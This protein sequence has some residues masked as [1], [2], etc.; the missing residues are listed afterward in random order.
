MNPRIKLA[1]LLLA[2]ALAGCVTAVP[3]PV[4]SAR[5][6]QSLGR[7]V[8]QF[9]LVNSSNP[10][11]GPDLAQYGLQAPTDLKTDDSLLNFS[12]RF[13]VLERLDL[14]YETTTTVASGST[15]VYAAKYQWLG[16]SLFKTGKGEWIASL[17]VKYLESDGD[18]D[19]TEGSFDDLLSF[20]EL[21]GHAFGVQQTVG[22][23]FTDWLV[24]SMGANWHRFT[25]RSRFTEGSSGD[26]LHDG[27]HV[28]LLGANASL[29][30]LPRWRKVGMHVCYERG[31]QRMEWTFDSSRERNVPVSAASVGVGFRF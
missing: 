22:Y 10:V 6:P 11:I 13:G 23:Q 25:L 26:P 15:S 7:N 8:L 21:K 29:C 3:V 24:F 9:D 28:S 5:P 27:R 31:V 16:K 4:H 12:V 20:D 19:D 18:Q 30:V 1:A 2:S 14:E 17:R